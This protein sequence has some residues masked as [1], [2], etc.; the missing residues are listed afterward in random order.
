[1]I[2]LHFIIAYECLFSIKFIV[3]LFLTYASEFYLAH[4]VN[5]TEGNKNIQV[6]FEYR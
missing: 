5:F 3:I 1:M 4:K 2:L 6:L